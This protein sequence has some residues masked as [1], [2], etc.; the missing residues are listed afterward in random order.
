M[1]PSRTLTHELVLS[2][3]P[4][5]ISQA[6][7]Y[8]IHCDFQSELQ[9]DQVV[10]LLQIDCVNLRIGLLVDDMRTRTNN[11]AAKLDLHFHPSMYH[12]KQI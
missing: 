4:A 12:G 11:N 8:Y 10:D 9:Y 3:W 1:C 2:C 7:W 6:A 5:S